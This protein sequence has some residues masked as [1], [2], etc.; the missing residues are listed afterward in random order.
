MTAFWHFMTVLVVVS[1]VLVLGF[2]VLLS[3]PK[4]QL[5]SYI[6]EMVGWGTTAAAGL[7]VLSL[8][9]PIPDFIPVLGQLDDVGAIFA[10][11]AALLTAIYQRHRRAKWERESRS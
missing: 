8:I 7:S 4:S 1:G 10:G 3:L 2:L 5:R 6:L 11:I 9:D